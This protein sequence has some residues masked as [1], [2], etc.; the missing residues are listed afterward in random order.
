MPT[1]RSPCVRTAYSASSAAWRSAVMAGWTIQRPLIPSCCDSTTSGRPACSA[2]GATASATLLRRGPMTTPMVGSLASSSIAARA[3]LR[4]A[5]V[6]AHHQRSRLLAERQLD[7]VER[8][9][10]VRR[11]LAAER[12]QHGDARARAG[13]LAERRRRRGRCG[14]SAARRKRRRRGLRRAARAGRAAFHARVDHACAS[15]VP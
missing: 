12:Q 11:V 8:A 14:R 3:D 4:L 10:A 9:L 15:R 2:R 13:L 7:A 5:L 1:V 6:V